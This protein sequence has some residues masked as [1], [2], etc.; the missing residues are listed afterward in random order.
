MNMNSLIEGDILSTLSKDFLRGEVEVK[1][2]KLAIYEP[3]GHFQVHRDTVHDPDHKA[4]LLVELYSEH[5]GGKLVLEKDGKR[6]DWM[7]SCNVKRKKE[8]NEDE[9]MLRWC[10][11]YTDVEHRVKKV[12]SGV[13]I[14]LQFD[15]LVK[16]IWEKEDKTLHK[17]D[18]VQPVIHENRLIQPQT[19]VLQQI[20]AQ[21][22]EIVTKEHAIA[23]PLYYLYTSETIKPES[24]KNYDYNL[25][26]GLLE[27]GDYKIAIEPIELTT[28][29]NPDD[30]NYPR[31]VDINLHDFPWTLYSMDPDS[32]SLSSSVLRNWS[33][34]TSLT[35]VYTG[36]E[37]LVKFHN[38]RF[39]E[40]TGNEPQLAENHYLCGT[41]IIMKA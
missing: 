18:S 3:G 9:P 25:L 8:E 20:H 41:L 23:I 36:K 27:G 1:F 16:Q 38:Q 28:Y 32:K 35:Y 29:Y 37:S 13:R 17:N 39:I 5:K 31:D 34:K 19:N 22:K 7:L 4:T 21:L 10:L 24:L 33:K 11:F 2:Y 40:Y 12:K 14:V 26:R 6:V 30:H 15:V